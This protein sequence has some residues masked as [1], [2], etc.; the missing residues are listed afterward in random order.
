MPD[1]IWYL[2]MNHSSTLPVI[3]MYGPTGVGKT[4][5]SSIL[6]MHYPI[7]IINMDMGQ[8]YTP[9]TIGTAKPDWQNEKIPHHLFDVVDEPKHCNVI[10]Y[11]QWVDSLIKAIHARNALPVLVGG[12]GFYLRSLFFPP[13][14]DSGI[15]TQVTITEKSEISFD[16]LYA[17][18]PERASA[19][20]PNDTY[21]IQRALH[22]WQTTGKKPLYNKPIYNPL[23][24]YCVIAC[25][26]RDTQELY[27]RINERVIA[28]IEKGWVKEVEQLMHTPWK[29]FINEKKIIGYNDIS[30]YIES[31]ESDLDS[32]IAHI[33]QRTRNYAKRQMTFWRMLARSL[34]EK[35]SI[36]MLT[37]NSGQHA[38]NIEQFKKCI[39]F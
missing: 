5:F 38:L 32:L 33:Q 25:L 30:S 26:Q 31:D 34:H 35:D 6:S 14:N 21:R 22:I 37:L 2:R 20:H 18:D 27:T 19:I 13:H 23:P 39:D 11:R 8:L 15:E 28:M 3:I 29:S 7:E 17:I 9:L 24:Y 36:K 4:D 1:F 12:S 16:D 10:A